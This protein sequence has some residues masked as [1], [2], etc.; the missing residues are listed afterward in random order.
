MMRDDLASLIDDLR[1]H[2]GPWEVPAARALT[3]LEEHGPGPA[4]WP[5]WETGA[6][7]YATLTPERV[8]TLDQETTLLLLSGLAREEE[9]RQGSWV[10]MFESGRGTWLFERWLELAR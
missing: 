4:D 9:H 7:L 6:E 5:T 3:F 8:S 2:A 10:A 1:Q